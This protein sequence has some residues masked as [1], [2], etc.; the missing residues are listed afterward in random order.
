YHAGIPD[1]SSMSHRP[2]ALEVTPIV[3]DGTMYV[4]TPTGIVAA[5]D[6]ATGTKRWRYDAGVNPH[7]GYCDFA[8]RDVR[9]A[10]HRP[11]CG[12]RKALHELRIGRRCRSAKG[13]PLRAGGVRVL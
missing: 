12:D 7:R 10:A 5:L 9:R 2:P 11:R 6:P 8:S 1:M 4:I 3:V 13:A